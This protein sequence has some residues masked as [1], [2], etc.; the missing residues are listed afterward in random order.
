MGYQII[1]LESVD[2]LI[3]NSNSLEIQVAILL[4]LIDKIRG[5]LPKEIEEISLIKVEYLGAYPAIGLKY[6]TQDSI[7]LEPFIVERCEHFMGLLSI[8]NLLDFMN[9]NKFLINE[10]LSAFIDLPSQ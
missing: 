7:D 1:E 10:K 6:S 5:L 4:L 2:S 8:R 3:Q 9:A